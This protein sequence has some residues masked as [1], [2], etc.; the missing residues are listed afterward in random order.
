MD[1]RFPS[2][3]EEQIQ[4]TL[5][6]FECGRGEPPHDPDPKCKLHDEFGMIDSLGGYIYCGCMYRRMESDEKSEE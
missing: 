6:G 2:I 1:E 4:N 3:T 5:R